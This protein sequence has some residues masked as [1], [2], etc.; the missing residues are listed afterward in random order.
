MEFTADGDFL[1]YDALNELELLDGSSV[2]A[3]SIFALD[4]VSGQSQAIVPPVPGF[5]IGY[6]SLSQRSD[7]FVV[8]D[9]FDQDDGAV[10]GDDRQPHDRR[11]WRPIATVEGYGVPG[12][13]GDDTRHRLLTG[14]RLR[15]PGSR[16]SA[17][18]WPP[19]GSRRR[20][21]ATRGWATATTASST[22][23]ARSS[24]RAAAARAI[25]TATA[26]SPST[27]SSAASASR[28]ARSRPRRARAFDADA[29][30]QVSIAELVAAVN[31]ALDGC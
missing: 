30:G 26:P 16:W 20:A 31:A 24:A 3:W 6:P 13:T 4:L 21:I 12:Y 1:I 8:F 22:G 2:Q 23:A 19:T 14:Q 7:G 10:D 11:P 28:S 15:R 5:D 17:N 29:N 9:V 25:A 27:S 18:R